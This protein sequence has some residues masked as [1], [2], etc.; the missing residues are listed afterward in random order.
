M[1]SGS[2]YRTSSTHQSLFGGHESFIPLIKSSLLPTGHPSLITTHSTVQSSP[3]TRE[4][5]ASVAAYAKRYH[6]QQMHF[7]VC[8]LETTI[9]SA[10]LLCKCTHILVTYA[11]FSCPSRYTFIDQDG[12]SDQ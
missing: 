4:N 5:P 3:E 10:P 12:G 8:K 6:M 2:A 1:D 7:I 9:H 11:N